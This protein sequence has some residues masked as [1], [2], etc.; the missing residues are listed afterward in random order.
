MNLRCGSS[1]KVPALQVQSPE[2]KTLVPPKKKRK[3]KNCQLE[4]LLH[5]GGADQ[6]SRGMY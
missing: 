1:S 6:K 2:F 3:S 4:N 5:E